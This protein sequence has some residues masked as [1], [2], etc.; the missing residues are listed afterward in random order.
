MARDP[1]ALLADVIGAPRSIERFRRGLDLDG[2]RTDVLVR[3]GVERKLEFVGEALN[4]LSREDPEPAARIPDI[5]RIIGFPNVLA[6]G[7]EIVDD[8][9]VWDAI[10]T[11][12][13]VLAARVSSLLADWRLGERTSASDS[14]GAP[15]HERENGRGER[16]RAGTPSPSLIIPVTNMPSRVHR[17]WKTA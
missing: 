9:V 6:H 3:S 17:D 11:D 16:S 5:G 13:P 1:R 14:L 2:F 7:Y 10:T 15:S 8:E 4:R 12:L